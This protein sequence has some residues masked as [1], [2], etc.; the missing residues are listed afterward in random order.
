MDTETHDKEEIVEISIAFG[1]R[2]FQDNYCSAVRN[3]EG[4]NS[5]RYFA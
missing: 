4:W 5:I 3:E 1:Y 2:Q